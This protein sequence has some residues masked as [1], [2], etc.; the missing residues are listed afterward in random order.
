[1]QHV[2]VYTVQHLLFHKL[3]RFKQVQQIN[4]FVRWVEGGGDEWR[5]DIPVTL[6]YNMHVRGMIVL[7]EMC[8]YTNH[9]Y[10][11]IYIIKTGKINNCL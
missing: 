3:S 1:V 11:I 9:Y 5:I 6:Y 2:Y 4:T 7:N 10:I 8:S